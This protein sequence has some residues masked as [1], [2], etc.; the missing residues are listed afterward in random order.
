MGSPSGRDIPRFK[1]AK[2]GCNKMSKKER[3]LG[4]LRGEVVDRVP[5]SIWLHYPH[6]DQDPRSLAE[7]QVAVM[8]Q[9]D[10][11]FIKLMPFGLYSVQDWGCR[12]RIFATPNDPPVVDDYGI[13]DI[14]DWGKL[15]ELPAYYGTWGK[16]VQL[17]HYVKKLVGDEVPFVQ[18]I[19]SPL[20]TARKLAGDRIFSDM[21]KDPK[22]F[23]EALQ[24]ITNTT[25]NFIEANIDAGVSGFFFATQLAT[26]D[27]MSESAYDEFG[28]RYDLQL[29]ERFRDSTF[30]NIAHIHG[31]N[32]M[33]EK[34]ASYPANCINWHDRWVAPSL[35]RARELTDKCLLGGIHEKEVLVRGRPED[36]QQH[37]AEAIAAA[38]SRGFMV[39]P[40]CVADPRTPQV[41]YFAARIA[42][43]RS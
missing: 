8:R 42:V 10:F 33:F 28:S 12:I 3:V 23:H 16:Q 2:L 24:V 18:T 35:G 5:I 21:G 7:T 13:K 25:I 36:V 14:G 34:I 41:N 32:I 38:G 27:L 40:G 37:V 26:H 9:Y 31:D 30:F 1:G 11:D 29:F 43:E 15:E 17:A 4:A 22:G 6:R 19:F 20:T 39:G